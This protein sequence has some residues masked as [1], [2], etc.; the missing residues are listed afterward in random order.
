M[1]QQKIILSSIKRNKYKRL[2]L[3]HQSINFFF[4]VLCF[5][6][7]C[8]FGILF[9]IIPKKEISEAEQRKLASFPQVSLKNVWS[10]AF[11]ADLNVYYSDNFVFRDPLVKAKFAIEERQGLRLNDIKIYGSTTGQTNAPTEAPILL[12]RD[13]LSL[14]QRIKEPSPA[15]PLAPIDLENPYYSDPNKHFDFNKADLDDRF[16]EYINLDDELLVGEQR[17]NLFVVGNTALEIFYGNEKVSKDYADVL[18]AYSDAL[19]DSVTIYDLIVPN[20]FEYG[21]P[22]KY[23]GK[24]GRDERPFMDIVKDNLNDSIVFVDIYDTMKEHYMRGEYLYFRTD[25]HWTGLGAYRAYEKFCENA[26]LTPVSIDSYEK[27]TSTGFLGTLYNSSLDKN[28]AAEPDTVEYYIPYLSYEQIN[29]NKDFSTYKGRLISEYSDGRTNGY[30]TFMGGDI[31]LATITTQNTTGKSIIVFKESYGNAFIPFLVPHY[32]RIYV[33]DIRS[34][35]YNAISF[36]KDNNIGEV[37]FLNN[38]MT[39]NTS[40]RI[41]NILSLM[42]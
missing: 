8:I 13:D 29:T 9:F 31:P 41:A 40:A 36:I 4:L 30:L 22:T 19:G 37:L 25:H 12:C 10:G 11:T 33:A 16:A 14:L 21:L 34:F 32:D 23:K 18:N 6:F 39:S 7:I 42:R 15:Q 2:K 27:R 5:A 26:S 24:I 3:L 38:I 17:G 28:L 20:H 35:P 1:E